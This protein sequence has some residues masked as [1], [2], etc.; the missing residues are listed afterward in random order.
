[1]KI[2]Y[3]PEKFDVSNKT[4]F[5]AGTIDEGNSVDWQQ[6]V[7]DSLN[8]LDV[9]LLNPR[10]KN[11]DN[12]WKQSIGNEKFVEQVEWELSSLESSDYIL[13]YYAKS[14]KSPISLLELGLYANSNK[15]III[16]PDGFWRKGNVEIVANKYNIPLFN[17]LES[18]IIFLKTKFL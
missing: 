15:M 9:T 17:D 8:D 13:M 16:C 18:G 10:R 4:V 7:A 6:E 5:L 11:W 2:I 1:M 14:S 3:A 12:T